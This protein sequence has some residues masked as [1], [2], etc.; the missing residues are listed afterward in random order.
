MPARAVQNENEGGESSA[1]SWNTKGASPWPKGSVG[2][3]R[4]PGEGNFWKGKA[5]HIQNTFSSPFYH[6]VKNHL[7]IASQVHKGMHFLLASPMLSDRTFH[8]LYTHT[9]MNMDGF[10]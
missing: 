3:L 8:A 7:S 2:I 1:F 5:W 10:E 6:S 4:N 9:D